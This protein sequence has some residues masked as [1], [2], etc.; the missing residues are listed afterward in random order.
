MCLMATTT[1]DYNYE[2]TTEKTTEDG[3]HEKTDDYNKVRTTTT[4]RGRRRRLEP[5][6]T[7]EELG[8][9]YFL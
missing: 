4:R 2:K 6:N 3:Y 9:E 8:D 5:V 7:L 1:E